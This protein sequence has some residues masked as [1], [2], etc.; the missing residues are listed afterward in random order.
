MAAP[1]HAPRVFSGDIAAAHKLALAEREP[2]FVPA[3]TYTDDRG[4]SIMNQF[5]GVLGPDGQINFTVQYP[6]VVKAWHR[7]RKQTDFWLCVQNHIK[8]GMHREEDQKSWSIVMGEKRQGILIIPPPL[9]HGA[10][11]AGPASAGLLYY[12]THAYDAKSPDEERRAHDSVPEFTW[13]VQHR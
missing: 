8:V 1:I 9:W 3:A 13:D 2:V 7:H 6:G 12:V 11:V 5:Q 10:T 4:W